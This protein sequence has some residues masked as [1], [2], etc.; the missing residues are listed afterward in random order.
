M[1]IWRDRPRRI[2]PGVPAAALPTGPSTA[3]PSGFSW[4]ERKRPS[5]GSPTS[6]WGGTRALS[7]EFLA[8][9]AQGRCH[10][11]LSPATSR[12][13]RGAPGTGSPRRHETLTSL[14]SSDGIP[15]SDLTLSPRTLKM[16]SPFAEQRDVGQTGLAQCFAPD[17]DN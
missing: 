1:C 4:T 7:P 2:L 13:E 8:T 5:I 16:K 3:S 11:L 12:D 6:A 15:D 9:G 17:Q 14:V 10:H